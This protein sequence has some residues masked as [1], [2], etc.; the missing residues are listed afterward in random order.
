MSLALRSPAKVSIMQT[1][2]PSTGSPGIGRQKSRP[3]ALPC[4]IETVLSLRVVGIQRV[5][6]ENAVGLLEVAMSRNDW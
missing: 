1:R 5:S 6:L 2:S 3:K 4:T